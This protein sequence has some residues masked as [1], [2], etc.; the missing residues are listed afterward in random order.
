VAGAYLPLLAA[1]ILYHP[2]EAGNPFFFI[3]IVMS[4]LGFWLPG[5][6]EWA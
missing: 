3:S 4:I 5:W 2:L 1:L 6:M